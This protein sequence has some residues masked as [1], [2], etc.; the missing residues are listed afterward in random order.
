MMP[1]PVKMPQIRKNP[2]SIITV[3]KP[4]VIFLLPEGTFHAA[5]L[6]RS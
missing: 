3:A 5:A 1:I 6:K 2:T 4:V